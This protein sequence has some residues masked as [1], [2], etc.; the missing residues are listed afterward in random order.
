[1]TSCSAILEVYSLTEILE[2]NDL[3]DEDVLLVLVEEGHV[4]LPNIRPLELDD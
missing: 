2:L 1:M 3:T 4:K